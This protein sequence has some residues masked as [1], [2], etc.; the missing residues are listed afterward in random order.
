MKLFKA[1]LIRLLIT[2]IP[3]L[4]LYAYAEIAFQ[5]NRE[6]EHPTD[7]GLGIAILLAFIAMALFIGFLAD[8]ILRLVR[9]E[10]KIALINIP[11][12][13]PFI[14]IITY[15]SCQMTSRECFCGWLIKVLQ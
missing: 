12:L 9:K 1:F 13:I 4:A 2:A 8:L 10:Y 7:V 14:I 11:F 5:A 6:K 3:L 15:I